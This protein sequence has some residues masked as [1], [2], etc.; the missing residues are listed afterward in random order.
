VQGPEALVDE[1][2][3]FANVAD[4]GAVFL[5]GRL[6]VIKPLRNLPLPTFSI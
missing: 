5:E 1:F 2:R 6:E 3:I 4:D